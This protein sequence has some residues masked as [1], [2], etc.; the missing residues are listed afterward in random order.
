ML[1]REVSVHNKC[2]DKLVPSKD[3]KSGEGYIESNDIRSVFCLPVVRNINSRL[4]ACGAEDCHRS[5]RD[6]LLLWLI[7]DPTFHPILE[8]TPLA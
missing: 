8:I 7:S 3:F 1:G 2:P 5:I 4:W 6:N